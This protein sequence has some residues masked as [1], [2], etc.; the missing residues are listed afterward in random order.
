MLPP[1]AVWLCLDDKSGRIRLMNNPPLVAGCSFPGA[2]IRHRL[3]L[4]DAGRRA[5]F[6]DWNVIHPSSTNHQA[7]GVLQMAGNSH[8][9]GVFN[10]NSALA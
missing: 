8:G 2:V 10:C 3:L 5:A 4:K 9:A 6:A 1:D 7:P